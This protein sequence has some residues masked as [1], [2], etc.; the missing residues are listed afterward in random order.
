[1]VADRFWYLEEIHP[2]REFKTM[3]WGS[4]FAD[5]C[6]R[7]KVK[8]VN[9]PVG[10]KSIGPDGGIHGVSHVPLN[11]MKAIIRQHVHFWQQEAREKKAEAAKAGGPGPLFGKFGND[12]K[13]KDDEQERELILES[14]LVQ[15]VPWDCSVLFH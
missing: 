6:F 10:M 2:D 5:L 3:K 4:A 7:Y 13:D 9:Y 11:Y 15:F 8:L 1:M 14:D 12:D